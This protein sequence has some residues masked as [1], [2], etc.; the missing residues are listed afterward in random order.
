MREKIRRRR[1]LDLAPRPP[2]GLP[3][4]TPHWDSLCGAAARCTRQSCRLQGANPL[5]SAAVAPPIKRA[6]YGAATRSPAACESMYSIC[7]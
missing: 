1:P 7:L 3:T 4:G 5:C 2:L 6:G